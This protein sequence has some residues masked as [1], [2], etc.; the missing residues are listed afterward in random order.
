MYFVGKPQFFGIRAT[1][2]NIG[3]SAGNY[4]AEMFQEDFPQFFKK[5]EQE[6]GSVAY[7]SLLPDSILEDLIRQA[8]GAVQ[9]DKWLDSWRFAA[10]LYVEN[11]ATI[12]LLSYS[13]G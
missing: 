8:N 9:P 11:Y 2:S 4:R 12:Y 3:H 1:A 7:E 5:T 13:Y 10:G 6:D